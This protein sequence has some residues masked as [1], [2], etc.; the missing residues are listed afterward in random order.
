MARGGVRSEDKL[1][2]SHAA[3]WHDVIVAY[4]CCIQQYD[5]LLFAAS[6]ILIRIERI[7][8]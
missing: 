1:P 5:A 3:C 4:E 7:M 8:Y 6:I 2:V